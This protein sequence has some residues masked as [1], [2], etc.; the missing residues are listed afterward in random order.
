MKQHHQPATQT[1]GHQWIDF[2]L[3]LFGTNLFVRASLICQKKSVL[4]RFSLILVCF[5]W[6][7]R[8]TQSIWAYNTDGNKAL[9]GYIRWYRSRRTNNIFFTALPC[10]WFDWKGE[11]ICKVLMCVGVYFCAWVCCSWLCGLSGTQTK[12][13]TLLS[14]PKAACWVAHRFMDM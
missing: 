11:G 1:D 10:R 3:S 9:S 4:A 2:K 14:M 7:F 8:M 6:K 5:W 12:A 13:W